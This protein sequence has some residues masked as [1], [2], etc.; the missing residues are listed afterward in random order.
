MPSTEA[1]TEVTISFFD[2]KT[3]QSSPGGTITPFSL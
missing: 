3:A 2:L 1:S